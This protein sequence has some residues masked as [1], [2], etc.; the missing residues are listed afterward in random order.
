MVKCYVGENAAARLAAVQKLVEDFL[1]QYGDM[2][3]ER[4]D[5]AEVD[6]ARL[7]EAVQSAPFLVEKKL[8]VI[9][10][11]SQSKDLAEH[12]EQLFDSISESSDVLLTDDKLDKRT[13]FFKY[14]KKHADL[15]EFV[16]M[17]AAGLFGW[18]VDYVKSAG[19]SISSADARYLIEQLTDA[20][21]VEKRKAADQLLVKNE[22]DK[23]MIYNPKISRESID[24]LVEKSPASRVFDLLDAAFAGN[25][26][27]TLELYADQRAQGVEPQQIIAMLAWQLHVFAVIKAAKQRSSA[28]IVSGAKLS[29]Y[30]VD[31]SRR[32]LAGISFSRLKSLV[33]ELAELDV[34]SKRQPISLD[35]A[36]QNYLI[37]IWKII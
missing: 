3:V 33:A 17:D 31:K 20:G 19:G 29:P 14:L 8:I 36:V 11:P 24:L 16:E 21:H 18:L 23:L 37:S 13:Q 27:R 32:I 1:A 26:K 4:L 34:R 2:A 22:L 28:E 35:E 10:S 25:T 12:F 5:A 7:K 15:V 6:F 30:V 9:N